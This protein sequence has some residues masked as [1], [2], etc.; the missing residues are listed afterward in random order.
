MSEQNENT[1][2]HAPET[3]DYPIVRP[4]EQR[5]TYRRMLAKVEEE[6]RSRITE[7]DLHKIFSAPMEKRESRTSTVNS[8]DIV[9]KYVP[10]EQ[11]GFTIPLFTASSILDGVAEWAL[12]QK[13]DEIPGLVLSTVYFMP[14][15]ILMANNFV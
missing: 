2:V 14:F 12:D 15:P 5:K 9:W 7:E 8:P 13:L 4:R 6:I 3:Q 11:D 1:S 10:R